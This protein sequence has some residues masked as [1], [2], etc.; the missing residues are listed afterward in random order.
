[1]LRRGLAVTIFFGLGLAAG[2]RDRGQGAT[3][4]GGRIVLSG[5]KTMAPLAVELGKR[6]EAGHP[7][8][9]VQVEVGDSSRGIADTRQG[10]A[11]I[12][13]VSRALRDDE[14]DLRPRT[15]AHDGVSVIVHKDNPVAALTD[16]QVTRIFTGAITNWK[17]VGGRDA[18][19]T[20][21]NRGGSATHELFTDYFKLKGADIKAAMVAQDNEQGLVLVSGDADA[22]G[23]VAVGMAEFDAKEGGME[24]KLLPVHGVVA[25]T[26]AVGDGSFP[27]SRPLALVTRAE[28]VGLVRDFLDFAASKESEELLRKNF[29]VP[30]R[31]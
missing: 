3:A 19:I 26:A 30:A 21:V 12:G 2:C 28:P 16:E 23:Y 17:D 22:I 5:S 1:M 4:A 13:M 29:F 6:F 14:K 24:I 20:V 27:I 15:L 9:V 8:V 10:K 7:G 31:R 18:K 25:T 11:D